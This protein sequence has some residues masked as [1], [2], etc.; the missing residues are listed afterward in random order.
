MQ[1]SLPFT[2][3][4]YTE[5]VFA[6]ASLWTLLEI[7]HPPLPHQTP[8]CKVYNV[9]NFHSVY[10]VYNVYLLPHTVLPYP[11]SLDL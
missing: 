8:L 3:T 5:S 9:Y 6:L 11:F 1:P 2:L 7:V 4:C 10:N